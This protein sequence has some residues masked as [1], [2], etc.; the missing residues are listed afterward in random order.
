MSDAR[1]LLI[2]HGSADFLPVFQLMGAMVIEL[3]A[4]QEE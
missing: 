2:A 4:Q 3:D 1:K